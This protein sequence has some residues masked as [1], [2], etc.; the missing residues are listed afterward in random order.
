MILEIGLLKSGD[1]LIQRDGFYYGKGLAGMN[2]KVFLDCTE[3]PVINKL[4]TTRRISAEIS[5]H[6]SNEHRLTRRR[7]Q[8]PNRYRV[9]TLCRR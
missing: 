7:F 1:L 3:A 8:L 4:I 2:I 5:H 9:R 6:E